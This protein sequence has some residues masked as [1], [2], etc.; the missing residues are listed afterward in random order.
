MN[1]TTE[2]KDNEYK[3]IDLTTANESYQHHVKT[4]ITD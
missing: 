1:S 3:D 4:I 2:F